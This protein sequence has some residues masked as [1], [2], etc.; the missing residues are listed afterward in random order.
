MLGLTLQELT[1]HQE[2]R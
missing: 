1:S 2:M